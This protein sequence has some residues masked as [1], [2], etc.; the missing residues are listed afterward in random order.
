VPPTLTF[1]LIAR[2]GMSPVRIHARPVPLFPVSDPLVWATHHAPAG[3]TPI[4]VIE[5]LP[6]APS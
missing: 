2:P 4:D 1:P 3:R 6:P 5:P